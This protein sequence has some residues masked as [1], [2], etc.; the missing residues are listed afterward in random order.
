MLV[1]NFAHLGL[2]IVQYIRGEVENNIEHGRLSSQRGAPVFWE[3]VGR[4]LVVDVI[5]A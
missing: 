3:R 5:R 4:E 1:D 2:M